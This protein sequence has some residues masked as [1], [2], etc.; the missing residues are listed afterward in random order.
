MEEQIKVLEQLPKISDFVHNNELGRPLYYFQKRWKKLLKD[1]ELNDMRFHDLRHMLG[2]L[3]INEGFSEEY[4]AKALG[5]TTTAMVKRYS[6]LKDT[7]ATNV[8]D[9]IR[10]LLS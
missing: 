7:K 2:C 8:V 3:A 6:R 1:N 4:I 10:R 9:A 5:H